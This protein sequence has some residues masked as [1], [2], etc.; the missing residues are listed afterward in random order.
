MNTF[1]R[2]LWFECEKV[3]TGSFIW[4]LGP[5]LVVLLQKDMEPFKG[6]GLTGGRGSLGRGLDTS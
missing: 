1:W 3:S 2:L 4:T 6:L 5:Q